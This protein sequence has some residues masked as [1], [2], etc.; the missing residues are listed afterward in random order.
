M[1][2]KYV[3]VVGGT[4]VDIIGTSNNEIIMEDSNPGKIAL[5]VGG[6]GRNIA[7][8]IRRLGIET[9]LLTAVGD[10]VHGKFAM[11]KCKK[12]HIDLSNVLVCR[13]QSTPVFLAANTPEGKLLAGISDMELCNEIS[14]EYICSKLSILNDAAAVV[15]DTNLSVETIKF[16]A[17][18]VKA[19]IFA[20]TVSVS[21]AYKIKEIM[22]RLHTVKMN[23]AEAEVITGMKIISTRDAQEAALAAKKMGTGNVY[24]T[25]SE[26]G[27]VYMCDGNASSAP[28]FNRHIVSTTGCGDAFTAA[29]AY[30][31]V[32]G[33]TPKQCANAGLA[34][35]S[36]SIGSDCAVST[37]MTERNLLRL[38][39][40]DK[41]A[42]K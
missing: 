14:P 12:A 18:N 27:V 5:S 23:L 33:F 6:V 35:A 26:R 19:P 42:L 2:E 40:I 4:G 10:D 32:K 29:L 30:G 3:V 1:S 17:E 16:I 39:R 36:I 8:N 24:I 22:G 41:K 28:S 13:G 7:E 31:Y 9:K 11:K 20:D 25:M 38:L 15:I 34:A 21:K 37:E